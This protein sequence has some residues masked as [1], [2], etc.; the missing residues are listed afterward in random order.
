MKISHLSTV[1]LVFAVVACGPAESFPSTRDAG[2]GD[3]GPPTEDAGYPCDG[4]CVPAVP[5]L[6]FG[7]EL[8]WLGAE[9][10]APSCPATAPVESY[11]GHGYPDGVLHCGA[12]KCDPPIGFCGLPGMLTSSSVLCPGTGNGSVYFSFGPPPGWDGTCSAASAI[13]AGA[14]CG[15]VPCVQ[16]I[17]ITPLM[18]TQTGC[19]PI[20]PPKVPPMVSTFARACTS[21]QISYACSPAEACAPATSE[22]GFKQCIAQF[23]DPSIIDLQCP[24]TYPK[25]SVFYTGSAPHCSPC[26]CG[27]PI[28]STCTGSLSIFEDSACGASMIPKMPIDAKGPTC[29]NVPAGAAL[30]SIMASEPSYSAGACQPSGGAAEGTVFCCLP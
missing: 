1:F 5:A 8:L 6:W 12:C 13:G 24:S 18:L 22:P 28:D 19:L 4:R 7:P 15:D 27:V 10:E 25:R 16:S 2:P 23:G 11:T 29:T 14:L 30:G 3:A 20:E 17:T 26:T 9:A 21:G